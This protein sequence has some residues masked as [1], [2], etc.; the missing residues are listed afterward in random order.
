MKIGVKREDLEHEL[1]KSL[2]EINLTRHDKEAVF[3]KLLA[4]GY[5]PGDIQQIIGGNTAL[6]FLS[7]I[8]LGVLADSIFKVTQNIL[9]DPAFYYDEIEIEKI[10]NF[11]IKIE[12]DTLSYPLI[13]DNMI[14]KSDNMWVGVISV[15]YF[16]QLLQ[17]RNILYNFDTQ[18]APM[19]IK[20]RN[21][22]IRRPNINT[23]SVTQIADL[24]I[25]NQYN[26]D[27]I[28][29]NILA[30]GEED[31]EFDE[32]KGIFKLNSGRLDLTDGAHRAKAS[33]NALLV[34]PNI[35]E[36][37][38]LLLTR[39]DINKANGYI[40]QKDKRN[41]LDEE[42]KTS[43]DMSNLNNDVVKRINED[44]TSDLAGMIVT[45]EFLIN[46]GFG[47]T[48]FSI[49]SKTIGKLWDIKTRKDARDLSNY[50]I[51]FFNELVG[52]FPNEL[53]L[54]IKNNKDKNFINHQNMFIYYLTIAKEIQAKNQWRLLLDRIV[55]NTNFNTE[56]E[57]WKGSITYVSAESFDRKL[58]NIIKN[59]QEKIRSE[60]N[61]H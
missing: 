43:R 14:R 25:K 38:I 2:Y 44:S 23:E 17:T 53:K 8:E 28:T 21:A 33:E 36:N 45:D 57:E 15:K 59:Y 29:L 37:F 22:M 1:Y 42:T 58:P 12:Q 19:Y 4:R 3:N 48:L 46:E 16:V 61:E 24:M 41:P 55:D 6:E 7:Q 27:D 34:N 26:Y 32:Q 56:N 49:M 30:N 51:D 10:N 9:V 5:L 13:F 52:I 11:K 40:I 18:R 31:F 35:D 50:L 54:D 60:V 20:H 39:F 47:I